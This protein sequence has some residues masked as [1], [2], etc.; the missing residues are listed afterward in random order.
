MKQARFSKCTASVVEN[1]YQFRYD[2]FQ[3]LRRLKGADGKYGTGELVSKFDMQQLIDNY[4]SGY[5]GDGDSQEFV[6]ALLNYFLELEK[7]LPEGEHPGGSI[8][9]GFNKRYTSMTSTDKKESCDY[10]KIVNE[11]GMIPSTVKSDEAR[12]GG[13]RTDPDKAN[14]TAATAT[15]AASSTT[16][17]TEQQQTPL[18]AAAKTG[19]E[20]E[21]QAEQQESSMQAA[22]VTDEACDTAAAEQSALFPASAN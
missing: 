9:E 17:Q 15:A 2:T 12:I 6:S 3:D 7:K 4:V 21:M 18:P 16:G 8:L 5:N 14:P 13:G 11:N 1:V 10:L 22:A 19:N 20:P